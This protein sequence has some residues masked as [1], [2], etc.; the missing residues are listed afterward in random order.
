VISE[1]ME[2]LA[3]ESLG[4]RLGCLPRMSDNTMS[5]LY[6]HIHLKIDI[7]YRKR[8]KPLLV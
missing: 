2:V 8:V 5:C 1:D 3:S 6:Q 4:G 7:E